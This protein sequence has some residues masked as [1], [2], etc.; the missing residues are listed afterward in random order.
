[1]DVLFAEIATVE[2]KAYLLIVILNCLIN[3]ASELRYIGDGARIFLIKQGNPIRLIKGNGNIEYRNTLVI[4][5]FAEF[6]KIYVA[7]LAVLV[8]GIVRNINPLFL[9]PSGVPVIKK[10]DDLVASDR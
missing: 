9:I 3:H 5:G 4:L 1:M 8:S 2:D 10:S 7:S 6:N